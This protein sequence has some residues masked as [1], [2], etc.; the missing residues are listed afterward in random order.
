MASRIRSNPID[1]ITFVGGEV[2]PR[3]TR[4]DGLT[5]ERPWSDSGAPKRG[6]EQIDERGCYLHCQENLTDRRLRGFNGSDAEPSCDKPRQRPDSL[7]RRRLRARG[8]GRLFDW[9]FFEWWTL[10]MPHTGGGTGLIYDTGLAV[11]G[12]E[13]TSPAAGRSGRPTGMFWII[14]RCLGRRRRAHV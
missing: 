13:P 14:G 7:R 9:W 10:V 1:F 3:S 4:W 2:P 11:F 8:F 12:A 5:C 6:M